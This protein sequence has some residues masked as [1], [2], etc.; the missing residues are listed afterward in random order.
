MRI[1]I[2]TDRCWSHC[3]SEVTR[4]W[5]QMP[6]VKTSSIHCT[7][8]LGTSRI[9][10]AV[11]IATRWCQLDSWQ[12]QRVFPLLLGVP[13]LTYHLPGIRK[14]GTSPQFRMFQRQ[15]MHESL[16]VILSPL[17]SFMTKPNIVKCPDGHYQRAIYALG[18]YITDY[19][20]QV[21]L[22]GVRATLRPTVFQ[23]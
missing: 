17:R 21:L 5:R 14:D 15:L 1:Q 20:E 12:F 22:A 23:A 13:A 7:S 8:H 19:P 2:P 9:P 11:P 6:L 16:R 3:S 10:P 4:P 18:P